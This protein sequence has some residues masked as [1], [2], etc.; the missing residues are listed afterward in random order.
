MNSENY[1]V[2][3]L[4]KFIPAL[5]LTISQVACT[6]LPRKGYAGEE[7]KIEDVAIIVDRVGFTAGYRSRL[8]GGLV[9][10]N[11]IDGAKGADL[12]TG[13]SQNPNFHIVVS[14]ASTPLKVAVL[15]GQRLLRV[16]FLGHEYDEIPPTGMHSADVGRKDY[17]SSAE[18][19]FNAEKGHTYLLTFIHYEKYSDKWLP[20]ILDLTGWKQSYPKEQIEKRSGGYSMTGPGMRNWLNDQRIHLK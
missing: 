12:D 13:R 6:S 9:I 5:I 10:L 16:D 8:K 3:V 18:L 7:R 15:P 2:S 14:G 20:V 11:A 1:S 19:Q 4:I 17:R